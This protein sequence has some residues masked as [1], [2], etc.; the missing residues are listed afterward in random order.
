MTDINVFHWPCLQDL[1]ELLVLGEGVGPHHHHT[2]LALPTVLDT[3]HCAACNIHSNTR[4][5]TANTLCH[6]ATA[7]CQCMWNSSK[8]S[9]H[10]IYLF[11]WCVFFYRSS[12]VRKLNTVLSIGVNITFLQWNHKHLGQYAG[13]RAK[14]LCLPVTNTKFFKVMLLLARATINP[15]VTDLTVTPV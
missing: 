4:Q 8:E 13:V 10:K 9:K 5:Q 6:Q 15:T 2:S 1:Q 3:V 11:C 12:L 7:Q 14:S